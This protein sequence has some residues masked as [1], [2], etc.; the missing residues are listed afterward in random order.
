MSGIQKINMYTDVRCARL[1][2]YTFEIASQVVRSA[3]V[4]EPEAMIAKQ[5]MDDREV[6]SQVGEYP[7]M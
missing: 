6:S 7:H 2:L 1:Q 3:M 5:A 4:G